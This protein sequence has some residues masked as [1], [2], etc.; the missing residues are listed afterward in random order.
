MSQLKKAN[1][2]SKF[3]IF[4]N[5]I[6]LKKLAEGGMAEVFLA[7]PSSFMGNGRVLVIKRLLPHFSNQSMFLS[8]FQNEI[9][10]LMGFCHPNTIQLHDFGKVEDQPFIAMEFLNGKNLRDLTNKIQ[11]RKEKLPISVVLSLI[12]Q[13]AAGLDY[14]HTFSNS[15]TGEKSNTIHRDVSPQNLIVSYDGNL[16]VIDFGIAKANTNLDEKTKVGTIKGK[17]AYLSPEQTRGEA[18]DCRSDVFSLGIVAWELLTLTRYYDQKIEGSKVTINPRNNTVAPSHY[19]KDIESDLDAVILKALCL[20][21]NDRYQSARDFQN[22]LRQVMLKYYPSHTYADTGAFMRDLFKAE[23]EAEKTEIFEINKEVQHALF[24]QD[25]TVVVQPVQ[26]LTPTED[27]ADQTTVLHTR[28]A[29][30]EGLIKRIED[31]RAVGGVNPEAPGSEE[32]H[33]HEHFDSLLVKDLIIET[34]SI[35][36]IRDN[37]KLRIMMEGRV[38]IY[39]L[40]G[41]IITKA[42]V[43]NCCLGGIGIESSTSILNPQTPVLIEFSN[44]GFG[45]KMGMIKCEV[46]WMSPAQ[47]KQVGDHVGGLQFSKLTPETTKKLEDYLKNYKRPDNFDD[48]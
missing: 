9:Q 34:R 39:D 35:L 2:E 14:A 19:N 31:N 8:M 32:W 38:N 25:A 33:A 23:I 22:A 3:E 46:K 30:I 21:A 43:R 11:Q 7:R 12:T 36:K 1:A 10:V 13:A 26:Q 48:R 37:S 41:K 27:L 15:V 20:N 47:S 44:D 29:A 40:S 45:P 28:L 16:K 4:G 5:Y 17:A 18:L 42:K 24:R 6:L